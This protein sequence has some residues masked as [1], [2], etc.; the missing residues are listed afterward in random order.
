MNISMLTQMLGRLSERTKLIIVAIV[1]FLIGSLF[2]GR[3]GETVNG[4]YVP[5]NTPDIRGGLLDTRTGQ[6]WSLNPLSKRFERV[7]S[8]PYF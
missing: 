3:S 6:V 5:W 8:I 7:A 1:A 2:G 4:R